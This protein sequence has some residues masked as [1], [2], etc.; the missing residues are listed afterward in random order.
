[1]LSR[2]AMVL[3]LA[4]ASF[5]LFWFTRSQWDAEMRLWKAVGDASLVLLLATMAL[6][7]L[8]RLWRAAGRLLP[9]RRETGIWFGL[10]AVLHTV[11]ILDGWAR[12]SVQRFFGYEFIPQLGRVARIEPGF[13]LANLVGL[14]AVAWA[15]V[16]VATSSDRAL[17]RLGPGAWKWLHNGSYVVFWLVV[18]HTGYFL[19]LHYTASFHKQVPPPDWFRFP[20]LVAA[21]AV[22]ALQ[23]AAFAATLR[24]RGTGPR[25]PSRKAREGVEAGAPDA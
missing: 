12:W 10:L 5:A 7:P 15:L 11:L 9:L 22:V 17:R 14:V 21:G 2:H 25:N 8:A 13:G 16:L 1:M 4:A 18:L 24:S 20:F 19:F 23:L 6:G 3:V